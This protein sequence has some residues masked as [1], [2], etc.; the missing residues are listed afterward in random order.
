[1]N[2]TLREMVKWLQNTEARLANGHKI[3]DETWCLRNSTIKVLLK[4][5]EL[6]L[7][8]IE[9]AKISN[10]I[11]LRKLKDARKAYLKAKRLNKDIDP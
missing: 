2:D 3:D 1:M 11:D 9:Q 6:I 10:Q 8:L 7:L 5:N 4:N